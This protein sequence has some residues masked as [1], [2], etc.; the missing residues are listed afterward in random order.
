MLR[1]THSLLDLKAVESDFLLQRNVREQL[2]RAEFG[3]MNKDIVML[4]KGEETVGG[5]KT[6]S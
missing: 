6:A 1:Q 2:V 3:E 4:S 5:Q